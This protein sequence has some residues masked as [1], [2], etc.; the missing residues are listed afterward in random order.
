MLAVFQSFGLP[1]LGIILLIALIIFGPAQL[2][3]IGRSVGKAIREFRTSST[4]VSKAI[5]EGIEGPEEAEE[6][7]SKKK[8]EEEV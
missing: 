6:N 1:E 7:K 4:E 3:K 2:P 5:T 8:E